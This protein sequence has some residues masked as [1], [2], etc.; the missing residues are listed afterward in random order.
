MHILACRSAKGP[1]LDSK[2]APDK[3]P[4]KKQKGL[5]KEKEEEEEEEEEEEGR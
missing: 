2:A 1:H 3:G 5:Q 4:P